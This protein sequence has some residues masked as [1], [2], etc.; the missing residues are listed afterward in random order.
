ML[1]CKFKGLNRQ[2][3]CKW[4]RKNE[5]TRFVGDFSRKGRKCICP[6]FQVYL[7]TPPL[8]IHNSTNW[9]Q[10]CLDIAKSQLWLLCTLLGLP[11]QEIFYCGTPCK[12]S[13]MLHI[14]SSSRG[15]HCTEAATHRTGPFRSRQALCSSQRWLPSPSAITSLGAAYW[16]SWKGSFMASVGH[17]PR[18]SNPSLPASSG[19]SCW[20]TAPSCQSAVCLPGPHVPGRPAVVSP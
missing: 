5:S 14:H 7:K 16:Q 9:P 4:G 17:H 2:I 12:E 11:L 20:T 10:Q 6:V 3:L 15:R 1:K 19:R 18:A 13:R 8:S